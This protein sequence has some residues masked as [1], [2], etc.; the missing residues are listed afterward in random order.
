MSLALRDEEFNNYGGLLGIS[1]AYYNYS[2]RWLY[3]GNV[4][5]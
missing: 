5:G 1:I 3:S 2:Y 4:V